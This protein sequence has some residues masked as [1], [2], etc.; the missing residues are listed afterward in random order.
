M[1]KCPTYLANKIRNMYNNAKNFSFFT[2]YRVT[3]E[4]KQANEIY[5]LLKLV[6]I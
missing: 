6:K 2:K 3:I 5:C 4:T 1:Q